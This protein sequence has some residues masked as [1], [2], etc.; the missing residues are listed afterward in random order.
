M[1]KEPRRVPTVLGRVHRRIGIRPRG[2]VCL[3]CFRP[4]CCLGSLDFH[5]ILFYFLLCIPVF[6][7]LWPRQPSYVWRFR[8]RRVDCRPGTGHANRCPIARK[9]PD[10][11]WTL[12]LITVFTAVLGF[13]L[14][15]ISGHWRH[16]V[17]SA[18]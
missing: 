11:I 8:G 5:R 18:F 16:F 10:A 15:L 1:P 13:E 12:G 2:S 4:V 14:L 17:L 9:A 6:L 7:T 3:F